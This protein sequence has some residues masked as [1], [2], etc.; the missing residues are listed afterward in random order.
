MYYLSF[1]SKVFLLIL[2][3]ALFVAAT[4]LVTVIYDGFK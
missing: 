3:I 1:F 2:F 4:T